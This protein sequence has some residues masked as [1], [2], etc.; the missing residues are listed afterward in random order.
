LHFD[1]KRSEISDEVTFLC[2]IYLENLH[3][4]SSKF[5]GFKKQ[6]ILREISQEIKGEMTEL[7]YITLSPNG[8]FMWTQRMI[9]EVEENNP[10]ERHKIA[11]RIRKL[12]HE[13]FDQFDINIKFT[14]IDLKENIDAVA[15]IH[16][17]KRNLTNQ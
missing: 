3:D 14:K 9:E 4:F 5:G 13:N 10:H 2:G 12:V 7:D 16:E 15:L 17:V 1:C 6:S 8:I 11:H